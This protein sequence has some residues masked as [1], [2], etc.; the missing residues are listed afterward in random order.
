MPAPQLRQPLPNRAWYPGLAAACNFRTEFSYTK[1]ILTPEWTSYQSM[2]VVA[3]IFNNHISTAQFW[4]KKG[5]ITFAVRIVNHMPQAWFCESGILAI[6]QRADLRHCSLRATALCGSLSVAEAV[7]GPINLELERLD[8]AIPKD[9]LTMMTILRGPRQGCVRFHACP[10]T[11]A[12][13]AGKSNAAN[14][15]DTLTN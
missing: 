15:Q 8:V 10:V 3:K 6:V 2:D 14:P 9:P 1:K 13:E 12:R 7:G 11:V 4:E 5:F